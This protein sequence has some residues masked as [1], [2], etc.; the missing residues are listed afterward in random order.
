LLI[1]ASADLESLL[2]TT[3]IGFLKAS[4]GKSP[5]LQWVINIGGVVTAGAPGATG[6]ALQGG[7]AV[8]LLIVVLATIGA[9]IN[10][11]RRL[12]DFLRLYDRI[13][14]EDTP[15]G[16]RH[17]G[18]SGETLRA[19][20]FRYFVYTLSAPFVA[21]MA[22]SLMFLADYTNPYA[23][24]V[25]AFSVGFISDTVI[26]V[27]M[28]RARQWILGKDGRGEDDGLPHQ[29]G[30]PPEAG[31]APPPEGVGARPGGGREALDTRPED[32]QPDTPAAEIPA[33]AS[34]PP[35][36]GPGAGVGIGGAGERRPG[37][38]P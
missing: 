23:L 30:G 38:G 33:K 16:D 17:W 12:P 21:M 18:E 14:V 19:N 5:D 8:P 28:G 20:L 1:F 6:G 26:E 4:V 2:R 7:L 37:S 9:A 31:A 22:Y 29:P 34:S 32:G 24:A 35:V 36:N 13:P 25:V 11:L 15:T 3:P 27:V 10:M